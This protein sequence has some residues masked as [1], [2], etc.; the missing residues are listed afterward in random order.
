MAL[1]CC[2]QIAMKL[3]SALL[4]AALLG[5]P[6]A[7][8][9]HIFVDTGINLH[10]DPDGRLEKVKVIWEYDEF[11]SLLITED[12][13][14]DPDFDGV[15]TPAE[16]A[17]L[18]GFDMQWTPGFNGDLV[19]RQG[20]EPLTLS[21][22][23]EPTATFAD[24][25]ITTTHVRT[26]SRD[27]DPGQPLDVQPYDPT[28]YTAYDITRGVELVGAAAC[29]S[30][31]AVPDINAALAELSDILRSL[32]AETLP[33]DENLPDVGGMLATTIH[34]TCDIS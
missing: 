24:G 30:E 27:Q 33:T 18:Q 19:I 20:G 25:R 4:T 22:P 34:V 3:A 13:G 1:A 2:T 15:L 17:D 6:A 23:M 26:V 10:F 12:R 29:Q 21:G 28:Y 32:D 5:S 31:L 11:Y 8:H 9:P 16:V 7:A 14:L